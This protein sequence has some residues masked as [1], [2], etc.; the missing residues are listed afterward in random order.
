MLERYVR[1][2]E[3]L[4]I[5]DLLPDKAK[6]IIH[7]SERFLDYLRDP[8]SF[9][10]LEI[11]QL[12]TL[13]WNLV[14]KQDIPL[15]WDQSGKIPSINFAVVS[16]QSEEQPFIFLP[17]NFLEL[18]KEAPEVQI[19]VFAHIASECR[20]FYCNKITEQNSEQI[21]RRAQAFEAEALLTMQKIAKEE[22]I[23]LRLIP[24]QEKILAKF[25]NG[26]KDLEPELV[27]KTPQYSFFRPG[28]PRLN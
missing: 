12:T 5:P 20:D 16:N 28:D 18:T 2:L 22:G 3:Q 8:N 7:T 27:Y 25:P 6:E 24:F 17:I 14:G 23:T 9:P 10:N 26:I 21:N 11:N 1:E 13:M 4:P 19:G 15:V